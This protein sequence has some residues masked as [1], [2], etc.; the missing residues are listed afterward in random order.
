MTLK[1]LQL[2]Q[3]AFDK[4][5]YVDNIAYGLSAEYFGSSGRQF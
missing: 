4:L 5:R 2:C 3:T 1:K